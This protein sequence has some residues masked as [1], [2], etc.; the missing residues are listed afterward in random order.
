MNYR[1]WKKNYK[2]KH[3]YNPPLVEDKRKQ[4]KAMRMMLGKL[5][6][7]DIDELRNNIIDGLSRAFKFLGE[8]F[9]NAGESLKTE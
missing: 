3:G 4:A 7:T 9:T 1:Q 5:S 6:Q 2:K 8:V